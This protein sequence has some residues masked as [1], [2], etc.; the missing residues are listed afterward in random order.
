MTAEAE[1]E[2]TTHTLL[3]VIIDISLPNF[4]TS[5]WENNQFV[6]AFLVNVQQVKDLEI[7]PWELEST[8]NDESQYHRTIT[9]FHKIPGFAW[10]P[11][12]P[13]YIHSKKK[14]VMSY[15][16]E[17]RELIISEFSKVEGIPWHDID[18]NLTWKVHSMGVDAMFP[19]GRV[20]VVVTAQVI[21]HTP[22]FIQSFAESTAVT[23]MISFLTNWHTDVIRSL[24]DMQSL[25][26]PVTDLNGGFHRHPPSLSFS[27]HPHSHAILAATF[28]PSPLS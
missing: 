22:S 1:V 13:L 12:L 7:T 20:H 5:L 28:S 25:V 23:E 6:T 18:C 24:I 16:S 21:F 17:G 15:S 10:L 11:W 19:Q 26:M 8:V 27:H 4:V 9:A 14:E 3:D 2:A